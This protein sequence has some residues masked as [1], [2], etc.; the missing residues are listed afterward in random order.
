MVASTLTGDSMKCAHTWKKLILPAI[1]L[2]LFLAVPALAGTVIPDNVSNANPDF[3][4][5][6][7]ET[8]AGADPYGNDTSDAGTVVA[9][10][11]NTFPVTGE[12]ETP[13][14]E[15]PAAN[16]AES[17]P[18]A[19]IQAAGATIELPRQNGL[20]LT[21]IN[22]QRP[23]LYDSEHPGTYFFNIGNNMYNGGQNAIHIS[24]SYL[25]ADGTITVSDSPTGTFYITDTGG[26]G[27]E[28]E[29]VLL[30]AVQENELSEEF[31]IDLVVEGYKFLDHA[32]N[33]APTADEVG[34]FN[35]E[36]YV[37]TLNASDFLTYDGALVSQA[38][39]PSTG[40]VDD[41]NMKFFDGQDLAGPKYNLILVDLNTSI[42][43]RNAAYQTTLTNYGNPKVTYTVHGYSGGNVSF[44]P[45]AYVSYQTGGG[46]AF[47]RTVGWAS[48]S[49]T[50]SWLV[51]LAEAGTAPVA[52]FSADVTNGEAPLAVQFTDASSGSPTSWAWD[53]E[54]DGIV[55]STEQSP[56]HIYTTAG[57]YTV[58]LTATNAA[59]TDAEV[60]TGFI[61]VT[62]GTSAPVADFTSN[63]TSGTAPL[64]VTFMD[65]STNTP[66]SWAWTFG[67]H[68]SGN[69]YVAQYSNTLTVIHA[70]GSTTTM[71]SGFNQPYGVAV[72]SQGNAYVADNDGN[73]VY[74]VY[75]N[76][77]TV[78]LGSGYQNPFDVAVDSQ[79][80][81][82]VADFFNAAVK[83]IYPDGTTV[84]LGS[85]F[86]KPSGVAV[87]SQDNLYVADYDA[88][89][90]SKIYTNGTVVT[91]RSGFTIPWG[92]AV[93]FQNNVYATDYG[94][95]L[96][97]KIYPNG[98]AVTLGS[99]ISS[100]A[101][102]DVDPQGNVYV[103]ERGSGIKKISPDGAITSVG[104][105]YNSA[106]G[107]AVNPPDSYAKNPAY[108]YTVAGT[109]SVNL[110]V[111]NAAGS[112]A[113]VKAAYITVTGS[114]SGGE[115]PVADFTATPTSG[116]APL[117]V[118]FTDLSTGSPTSWS[119]DFGDG[120][121]ATEQNPSHIYTSAGNYTVNLT[122]SN[123]DGSSSSVK[124]DYITVTPHTAR[125]WTVGATG[126]DFTTVTDAIDS[127]L[128]VDGD[129]IYVYNG[130]Y[131][132]TDRLA[133][134]VTLTGEGNDLVTL[135]LNNAGVTITG[136]GTII[137]GFR[138]TNGVLTFPSTMGG[139]TNMIV[140]DCIFEST[141]D[142]GTASGS[143]TLY[144]TNNT[145]RGNE[146]R[147]NTVYNLVYL[148]GT[149]QLIENNTF[150][151]TTHSATLKG[152]IRLA[153]GSGHIIRDNTFTD[154]QMP[155][156]LLQRGA[157][158]V[159]L[160]NFNVP[161]G[162]AP[163]QVQ[164]SRAPSAF[165]WNT[166]IEY[167]YTYQGNAYTNVLGNY[168][169]TYTGTDADGDGIGD[170][171]YA[172]VTNQVDSAP[173]MVPVEYYI[174][175]TMAAPTA[176]FTA[177]PTSGDVPLTVQFTDLSTV[178][179]TSWSWDF[180]NDGVVDSTEQNP[181]HT[182]TAAGTY[183]VNLTVSNAAGS[184]SEV[185]ID[186][187]TVTGGGSG[188]EAPVA[189]FTADV[190]SGKAPLT[191]NFTDLS[192]G[193]PT[194]W[195][196]DFGDDT[197]A[198]EQNPQHTYTT[199]GT[200]NVSLTATNAD[201]S[202]TATKTGYIVA[203]STSAVPLPAGQSLN[204]YV[205]NDEGV[206]YNVENGVTDSSKGYTPYVFINNTYHFLYNGQGGGT[207]ALH[208]SNDPSEIRGQVTT[209]TNQS[210]E[211]WFTFTGGQP[212]LHDAVLLLAVNGT[213]PDDFS[214]RIRS[215]GY[216]FEP[217]IPGVGNNNTI[218]DPVYVDG[219]INQT[220][221]K[222]DFIYGPQ[223][224]RPHRVS[225]Y[226]VF[227]GQD[228]SDTGN[229]F[230]LM[231][232]DLRLGCTQT[233]SD[234]YIR[235][236][237][238]FENL[239]SFAVFNGYGWYSASNHGTG[240]IMTTSGSE[241]QVVGDGG[242]SGPET[243]A[244][245]FTANVT[246]GDAPLNVQ[247]TDAS[248]GS[249]TSWAWD[250]E[251][252]GVV[253]STEQNP[254]FT[255]TAAGTYTVNLT[256]TN[257]AGTD[258]E[259][260]TDYIT[261]SDGGSGGDAPVAN[262]TASVTSGVVPLFVR[263]TDTS[264]NT[265]TSWL[266]DF[267][268]GSSSTEQNA[269]H[270]Y[271]A[272]GTYTVA[273]TAT[274]SAGSDT[275]TKT[276]LITVT[277][278]TG[279]LADTPWPKFG[280]DLNNSGLAPYVGT[281]STTPKWEYDP[282]G[283]SGFDHSTPVIGSDGTIYIGTADWRFYAFNPDGTAKWIYNDAGAYVTGG[284]IY[285]SAAIGSDGTIY[286]GTKSG[287]TKLYAL[288]PDGTLKW[289]SLTIGGMT[290]SPAI[291]SDGT[292]YAGSDQI[293]AFNPVDGT[294]KW[295]YP[296]SVSYACPAIDADGTIYVGSSDANV[297][298]LN[299][300][301]TLKWN[302]TTGGE[303]QGSPAIG[304][305][306]TIYIG[307]YG[308]NNV[309]A[310]NPD[311]TLKWNFDAGGSIQGSPA[312][313][314]DGTI[315]IGTYG[316]NKVY[317]L[318]PDGTQKWVYSLTNK[319]CGSL[320]IGADGTIYFVN[321]SRYL[322]ALNP[323]GTLKFTSARLPTGSSP[324]G[325]PAIGPDGT[326][327]FGTSSTN[328]RFYA[329]PGVVT[330]TA[331]T[332][333]GTAPL[334]VQ[335]TGTSPLTVTSWHWDFGDGTT[336][337]EQNPAHTYSSAGTYTVN[338]TVTHADGTNY[339]R[340][341]DY[342]KA[343]APPTAGF[344]AS[345]T[346]GL[347]PLAVSFTDQS[348]GSPTSWAW[349]FEND[350]IVDSTEQNPEHTYTA[351]GTYTVNLTA[352][353]AAG[354]DA[355][356]KTDY[357]TVSAPAIPRVSFTASHRV[358]IAPLTIR[359]ADTSSSDPT[360]WLWDFGDG[361]SS[362]EQNATHTYTAVGTYT[363]NLTATN[364]NGSN[365]TTHA[366]Y[367][368]VTGTE[369]APLPAGQSINIYVA[370]DE[371][372]KYNVENGV[373]NP[374]R[375][376]PYVFIDNTYH[377]L[378]DGQ[379]GGTNAL[380]VSNDPS[381]T[382]GQVTTT[383]NQSG[384]FWLTFTGGQP[385]LHDAV[386]LL[387]V[388]GTIPDD[389]SV[390]IRSSGYDFEPPIPGVGNNNTISD[391]VYVDGA[392]NQ[393]FTTED[394]IYGPQIWRPHR[395]SD[396]PV[397]VGQDMSD[398]GNTFQLMFIDLR[399]GCT[400]TKSDGYVRV[401][402]EFNNLTS[403]A[404]FNGYGWYSAS[405]H[406]TG[407]IMTTSGTEYQVVG[408]GGSSGPET[409]AANFTANVTA[410]D[411]PLAVQFTDASTGTPTSW[412]WDFENDG[413]IDSTEQSPSFTY[414]AAGTYTVNLTVSNA[415]GS[416]TVTKAD[417]ITVSSPYPRPLPAYRN[418]NIYV[419]NDEGVKYDEPNG[420]TRYADIGIP[421]NYVNNT[422]FVMF[423]T[424][425][426][427]TNPMD[428]SSDPAGQKG[429][430]GQITRSTNQS[431]E[432]WVTFNGGQTYMHEGILMLAV[433]GT[434]PDDFNVHIRSS[435]YDFVAPIPSVGNND[436]V[437][438]P[439]YVEGAVDQTF[440]KEDFI[441]GPQIWRPF[442]TPDLPIYCGQDMS[443]T[444]NT[445]QLMFIDLNLGAMK[446]GTDQGSIKVEYQFNNL[447]T[448]AVFNSYGWYRASNHG[449]GIIM[450]NYGSDYAVI[451][452][453]TY[454]PAAPA[455]D[456]TATPTS[457]DAPL[458]VQFTDASSGDPT[459]W[460]WD[461]ENDGV[462]DSTEQNPSFT[463]TAAGTY[464]V[465][466]T[467]TNGAGSDTVTKADYITVASGVAPVADFTTTPLSGEVPLAIQF[468]DAS[469]N[470]PTSWAWDFGDGTTATEQNPEHTY[471]TTGTYT[472]NLT[473]ANDAG[474]DSIV[475]ASYIRVEDARVLMSIT[476]LPTEAELKV[477]A[478]QKFAAK[479]LDQQ[480]RVM[481]GISLAWFSENESVGTVD[482]AGMFT[483]LAPGETMITVSDGSV[484]NTSNVLVMAAS[485]E[486][487]QPSTI[488]IPGCNITENPNG[489]RTV[490]VNTSAANVAVGGNEIVI[491]EET[492]NVTIMTEGSPEVN[493]GI[494]NGTVAGIRI[495]TVPVVT[496]LGEAGTISAAVGANLT[497]IPSGAGLD[498][499]ISDNVSA[500]ARSA[501]ELAASQDGLTVDAVAYVM[502]IDRT[503][504]DNGAD[505]ADATIRMS[506][507]STWVAAHGGNTSIQIIRWA[508]DG[509]KEVLETRSIGFDG[510]VEIF[511]AFSPN[512]LSL[513]GLATTTAQPASP[514]TPSGTS[515][516]SGGGRSAIG[517]GAAENIRAGATATLTFG[518][519]PVTEIE[520]HA[521]EDIPNILITTKAGSKPDDA[522]DPDGDVY[523]YVSIECYKAPEGS[524]K[525]ATIR[526][527]VPANW[528]D[529][530][531][532]SPDLLSLYRYDE[533]TGDWTLLSTVFAGEENGG[534]AYYADS[535][536]FG[537]FAIVVKP[538]MKE[539][540][541][542]PEETPVRQD[543]EQ[544]VASADPATTTRATPLF[545]GGMIVCVAVALFCVLVLL[546]RRLR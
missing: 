56:S 277:V 184:D 290:G 171:S 454:A 419:A 144:G 326:V 499:T 515:S 33:V 517:I 424:A 545:S 355:E 92:V 168:W 541:A 182:Y 295:S 64:T 31:S 266:W 82:Y 167:S 519:A 289:G 218:S 6:A 274:N 473:V 343:Y 232:I 151:N 165:P 507:S 49:S 532:S 109:Y 19:Q 121:T 73:S 403:F 219:A 494:V 84:A 468:T 292:V 67:E 158:T 331:D 26:K 461:F 162:I 516:S 477:G 546:N 95:S 429:V 463:Y 93:D 493:D 275:G 460:A 483:A 17:N 479:P 258:A 141:K 143:V 500:G 268:D 347:F 467:V 12:T 300:D 324:L 314:S 181:Q 153:T 247:F 316:N 342:I 80:N 353:N 57:T 270:T 133:K 287:E 18:P 152:V 386:L 370:N 283:G 259:V 137:E 50:N 374:A 216:D 135:D 65:S 540:T 368:V 408:D 369:L 457:G 400:Q 15:T 543:T 327:Y 436:T 490:S 510:D 371:G 379:G 86:I 7:N 60:K 221:T 32:A 183:T 196:W 385:N 88:K 393:T 38:W 126:C 435:G 444:E 138:F 245:N 231:F 426:G 382:N 534:Y 427:G 452:D 528:V 303:I 433:N 318:N 421:Y 124:E 476:L 348:T 9:G 211:F 10:S 187:I 186:Y 225:D 304:S 447:T 241:Y 199:V 313:G 156:L 77:T 142:P 536:S 367:I 87:D 489:T 323:D 260:K 387:A 227:V 391:P 103:V 54:N 524:L 261:V 498:V 376:T 113:E 492:Y 484:Q 212:N 497:G 352:T 306:G 24:D 425:G 456:F 132:F 72:D 45:Y 173:L 209:T 361:S 301:G 311:G 154:N 194:S 198:T 30:I 83:K 414:T 394:F 357:I 330:G 538:D 27:Y 125:T 217:P 465:N 415:A 99:G 417:Y 420:I 372:V 448:F 503:N 402:Y 373:T 423:G 35:S 269:T 197:N 14:P 252:D 514:S 437:S 263:F 406:G 148:A 75:T 349:D 21:V 185:K 333:S 130:T 482:G 53:F 172:L 409:P 320:V 434:I 123:A 114:G 302:F 430:D 43:G 383:T 335:F 334:D 442:G 193:Y 380:H 3:I 206:K 441:Y 118:Q 175:A 381:N 202:T 149:A 542:S 145:L 305:D 189:N 418:I 389:F 455:A 222:E 395:V 112:D 322:Y 163:V 58:N 485:G 74:K 459:S 282:A 478:R 105:G 81:V 115:A 5:A 474:T 401:E 312:I 354:S 443:D 85:G 523:K 267:G 345:V 234:G 214:V 119:W 51:T 102:I 2:V 233:K 160:N 207:N 203:R 243:P 265:P 285:G 190:T 59:G 384:E 236:E 117:N 29:A 179:P 344:T 464:S 339:L 253:D 307:T 155:C 94:A 297:Y 346:S 254:T 157:A 309:Y 288:N 1:L 104:S 170:T 360:S 378:Y 294:I 480:G 66:T 273:L 530:R 28:D 191:V 284:P 445:F 238:D 262:F 428:V 4:T 229:T 486:Q 450:S 90:V 200:Y 61:T 98:T 205:A 169:N 375:Y 244:A 249:P 317:A 239:T 11:E 413:V 504:L 363:V 513:F 539:V 16:P 161:D 411:A 108:T 264:A 63:V 150:T 101:G 96:V 228:M 356:V 46:S 91:L 392:I 235:V 315:Y 526:F 69:V 291:G 338:L 272:A 399:L 512:G 438:D 358:G 398:T 501:F 537:Y 471:T 62:A 340:Q 518:E 416:D 131:P 226:P 251:N 230:E 76:G 208:V 71:G 68:P 432:F 521:Q 505:I 41:V 449:T 293:Y 446:T 466:L 451:G 22:K 506:V 107:V 188:G 134:S 299:S 405:N 491:R 128:V 377:F 146:F 215:S 412:A 488:D 213:I 298:A 496:D 502:N 34:D 136:T 366:D 13:D 178:S 453:G 481:G 210:G 106:N 319:V 337:T 325:T 397:F 166:P 308:D 55:D 359:F 276:D 195:L 255:Y 472:V 533:E 97:Y 36:A 511:E 281:Q 223:I 527:V 422:Y 487:N 341:T 321:K 79:G 159:Y 127:A 40:S 237:Y 177:T 286:F 404:V 509:T 495:D 458:A 246:A 388:N 390:R 250:F 180:E 47:D 520:V 525:W 440:T 470:V 439:V 224:W 522:D 116:D 271:L 278:G 332:T 89:T 44:A 296:A 365:A 351:A 139:A 129:T 204:L 248:T 508:E 310:L 475:R 201:G 37:A 220:F 78:A 164:G 410:G 147:N 431:G 336:S 535:A 328:A 42:V 174:D 407:I 362:T 280:G 48:R 23:G 8:G 122:S 39:K 100:P 25:T 279:G 462:I 52:D 396:Y 329:F 364:A 240:I 20:N 256:V 531:L 70:D 120:T 469:T 176:D 544:K 350:G 111:A 242:S 529:E 140:R 110:T 192:I 257:A